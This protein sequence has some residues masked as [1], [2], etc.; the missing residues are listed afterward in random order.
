MNVS[1]SIDRIQ[2]CIEDVHRDLQSLDS[3]MHV[4]QLVITCQSK[5][6]KE[7]RCV[8]HKVV[9]ELDGQLMRD[10]FNLRVIHMSLHLATGHAGE[11]RALAQLALGKRPKK[12]SADGGE[13]WLE[14]LF[15]GFQIE[16]L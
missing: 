11:H 15:E 2:L 13:K 7:L 4:T 5:L 14:K 10:W 1:H 3:I 16:G 9:N 8:H 12:S 6:V